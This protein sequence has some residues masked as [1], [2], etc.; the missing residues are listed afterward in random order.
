VVGAFTRWS[1]AMKRVRSWVLRHVYLQ[2][3]RN[4]PRFLQV[5]LDAGVRP[6]ACNILADRGMRMRHTSIDGVYHCE[7]A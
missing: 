3:R 5:F 4:D 2:V 6:K 1:F 7:R